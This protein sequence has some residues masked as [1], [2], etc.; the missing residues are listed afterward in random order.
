MDI[1]ELKPNHTLNILKDGHLLKKNLQTIDEISQ[2]VELISI[3][4]SINLEIK[5]KLKKLNI[6]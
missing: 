4:I 6:C 2:S 3:S 5:H 1:T